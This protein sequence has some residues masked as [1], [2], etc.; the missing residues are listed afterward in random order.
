M[1][2][3]LLREANL[4]RGPGAEGRLE[5]KGPFPNSLWVEFDRA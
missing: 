5:W 2:G 3:T 4:R 1:A